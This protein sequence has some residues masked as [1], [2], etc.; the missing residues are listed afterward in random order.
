MSKQAAS[1]SHEN[2]VTGKRAKAS[3]DQVLGDGEP[4]IKKLRKQLSAIQDALDR[5]TD[6][7]EHKV[8]Q[9]TVTVP[10]AESPNDSFSGNSQPASSIAAM[11]IDPLQEALG[12]LLNA[13]EIFTPAQTGLGTNN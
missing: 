9:P 2:R 3:Q 12:S 5:L 10:L 4:N 1:H 7:M 13:K 6:A 8:P 11:P